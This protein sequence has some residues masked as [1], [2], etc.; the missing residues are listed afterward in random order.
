[1]SNFEILV[2]VVWLFPTF[3]LCGILYGYCKS[4]FCFKVNISLTKKIIIQ[5]TTLGNFKIVNRNIEVIRSYDLSYSYEIWIVT[6]SS[7]LQKYNGADRVFKVPCEFKSI[8]KYKARAL[9]YSSHLRKNLGINTS[10]VKILFL[11]DDTIPSKEYIEKCFIADYDVMEGIIQPRLNYGTRY[12]YVE[13]MRTLACL[14]VCSVYQSHGHPVWVHGEGICVRASTEHKVGWAFDV[15]SSEDLVFGHSCTTNKMKWGFI[16]AGMYT[17]APWTFRDY[18]IQRRR[19]LWGN[20]HAIIR[21]LTWQSKFRIICFYLLGVSVL[22]VSTLGSIM[23][24][25]GFLNFTS[26]ERIFSYFSLA[27][28]L[29]IYCYIGYLVGNG[30]LKHIVL[31]MALAWYTSIMN[32]F[33]ICI[34]LFT[35]KPPKFDVIQKERIEERR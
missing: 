28:W 23:D 29:G 9:D 7:L 1:L 20:V 34:G 31:S 13:N 6:E 8:A 35:K 24:L 33:P 26:H 12:S 17:T 11:D 22:W 10:D 21:I 18:F 32:T 25:A 14:S 2:L 30:R 4:K 16:W 27:T 19:W 3:V 5:I 15:I